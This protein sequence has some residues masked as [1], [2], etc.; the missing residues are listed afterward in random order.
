MGPG[1]D[2]GKEVHEV[3][4]QESVEVEK[5]LLVTLE[6]SEQS[7]VLRPYEGYSS[8]QYDLIGDRSLPLKQVLSTYRSSVKH[9]DGTLVRMGK[10]AARIIQSWKFDLFLGMII[11]TNVVF[12]GVQTNEELVR[13]G[14]APQWMED[15]ETAFLGFYTLELLLQVAAKGRPCFKEHLFLFDLFLVVVG[16][17]TLVLATVSEKTGEIGKKCIV[18]RILRL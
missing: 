7:W 4:S 10:Y 13:P 16:C 18:L 6:S 8:K 12:I 5:T 17:G 9:N 2:I 11:I 15:T 3:Q 14:G 1:D